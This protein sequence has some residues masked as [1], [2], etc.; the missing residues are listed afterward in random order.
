MATI[1]GRDLS[2]PNWFSLTPVPSSQD[3]RDAEYYLV[4]VGSI[5]ESG[6]ILKREFSVQGWQ[7]EQYDV[8]VFSRAFAE[9][10]ALLDA[11][12][13]IDLWRT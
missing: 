6:S 12:V 8:R 4:E 1:Y 9:A 5:G 2:G 7:T 3:G 13:S 11:S 10:E